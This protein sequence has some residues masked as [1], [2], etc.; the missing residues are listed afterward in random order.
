MIPNNRIIASFPRPDR[1]LVSRFKGLPVANIGDVMNRIACFSPNLRPLNSSP[2]LGTAL[3]VKTRSG[4]VLFIH[5]AL[6]MAKPGDVLV[7]NGQGDL[8][9][10]LAGELMVTYARKKGLAGMIIDGA[11]RDADAIRKITDF[12]VYAAGVTPNGPSKIGG[13]EI[14]TTISCGGIMVSSG[15]IIVGDGDGAVAVPPAFAE[16]VISETEAYLA[17][18]QGIIERILKDGTWDRPWIAE[19]LKAINCHEEK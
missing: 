13:G 11:V 1:E 3:T 8:T 9:F 12:P 4:D 18:E 17:R 7:I 14:G 2:M 6:D 16:S 10:A 5:K 19:A 15:D